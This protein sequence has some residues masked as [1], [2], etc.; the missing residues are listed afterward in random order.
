MNPMIFGLLRHVLTMGGGA[1]VTAGYVSAGDVETITG[2][3]MAL[4]GV[5]WSAYDKRGR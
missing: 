2:A 5:A 1:L 4:I 3:V